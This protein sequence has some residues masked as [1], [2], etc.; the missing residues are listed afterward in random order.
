M[1]NRITYGYLLMFLLIVI[2]CDGIPASEDNNIE[3]TK[4]L[5]ALLNHEIPLITVRQLKEKLSQN[6][7]LILMDTREPAEFRVS[8]LKN[9]RHV[10]YKKFKLESTAD[11]AKDTPIV[12]YCSLGVR[13]EKIGKKLRKAGYKNVTNLFGG[14]FEW[15]NRDNPVFDMEKRPTNRIHTYSKKWGK[16]LLKGEKVY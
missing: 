4:K 8:H 11:I 6:H 15:I 2:S 13:S 1:K 5:H 16:W 10:G 3:H 12:V 7:E 9:A 14:L